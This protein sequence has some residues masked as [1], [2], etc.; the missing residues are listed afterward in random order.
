MPQA[1][2]SIQPQPPAKHAHEVKTFLD[3]PEKKSK[4]RD[5]VKFSVIMLKWCIS[6]LLGGNAAA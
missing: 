2:I 1:N 5:L 4:D 6:G 3:F